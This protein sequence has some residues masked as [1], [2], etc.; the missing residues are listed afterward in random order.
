MGYSEYNGGTNGVESVVDTTGITK[1]ESQPLNSAYASPYALYT[2]RWYILILFSF[3][4]LNQC[5]VWIT[6][7]TVLD[8]AKD[9]YHVDDAEINLLTAM[10]PVGYIPLSFF[11]S[12][13]IGEYGLRVAAVAASVFCAAG[14]ILRCFADASSFWMLLIA[15]LLNAA[16]GPVVMTVPPALSS[17]WFGVHERTFATAVG[18]LANYM[19]SATGFLLGLTVN[20]VQ[21]LQRLLYIEALGTTV[22]MVLFLIYFPAR[23]PKPPSVTAGMER[24]SKSLLASWRELALESVVVWSRVK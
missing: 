4:S 15:Q 1:L 7:G 23:P 11:S 12:W 19:G 22:L 13:I 9:L 6:Y 5:N 18:S 24:Q 3:L 8:T 17:V 20:N 21:Q 2:R 14:A 10:G 16:A